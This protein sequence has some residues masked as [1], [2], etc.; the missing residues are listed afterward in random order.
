MNVGLDF[1]GF[2]LT[3]NKI[4]NSHKQAKEAKFPRGQRHKS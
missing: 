1:V 2:T 4:Q 3:S